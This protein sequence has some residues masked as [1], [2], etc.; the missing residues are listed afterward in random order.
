MNN[1]ELNYIMTEFKPIADS[2]KEFSKKHGFEHVSVLDYGFELEMDIFNDIP[3]DP[4][5]FY[6]DKFFYK[7]NE[8]RKETILLE[9]SK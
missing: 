4:K 6:V 1:A 9:R 5:H 2:I 3:D 8:I 7:E